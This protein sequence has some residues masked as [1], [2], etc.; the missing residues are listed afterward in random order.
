MESF[1]NVKEWIFNYKFVKESQNENKHWCFCCLQDKT[2]IKMSFLWKHRLY[3]F[4]LLRF[5]DIIIDDPFFD[6]VERLCFNDKE[7]TL[8]LWFFSF[9]VNKPVHLQFNWL[10]YL[11][12]WLERTSK[13]WRKRWIE[14]MPWTHLWNR[15][16]NLWYNFAFVFPFFTNQVTDYY[17][18]TLR[19]LINKQGGLVLRITLKWA[20]SF[21]MDFRVENSPNHKW[22]WLKSIL[23]LNLYSPT[24]FSRDYYI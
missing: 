3:L 9:P 5:F 17:L 22:N 4:S 19:Y 16:G 2:W 23:E 18:I 21:I 1:Y 8:S 20:C 7:M 15:Y 24:F 6:F 11:P 13:P 12:K 10:C 14:S